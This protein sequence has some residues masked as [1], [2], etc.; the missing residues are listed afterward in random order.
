MIIASNPAEV[1][2]PSRQMGRS[3]LLPPMRAQEAGNRQRRIMRLMGRE[4][5]GVRKSLISR[6]LAKWMEGAKMIEMVSA[7]NYKVCY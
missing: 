4:K 2:L 6:L 3:R 7:M 5:G 1:L